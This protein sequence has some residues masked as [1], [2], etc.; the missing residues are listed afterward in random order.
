MNKNIKPGYIYK[1]YHACIPKRPLNNKAL[2]KQ[3]RKEE[4]NKNQGD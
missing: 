3:R 2:K 1:D 4:R